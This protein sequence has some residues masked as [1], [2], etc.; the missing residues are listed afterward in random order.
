VLREVAPNVFGERKTMRLETNMRRCELARVCGLM[1][2]ACWLPACGGDAER[3]AQS[4]RIATLE[5]QV[6]QLVDNV[7]AL[8]S[9]TAAQTKSSTPVSS[10]APA[11]RVACPQPWLIHAPLGAALWSCRAP[12]PTPQGLY[13]QCNV[14]FQ[15]QV[16]I[17]T[18][19]YFELALNASPQLFEVKNLKDKPAKINGA[20][21]FEAT[22][23]ADPKPVPLTMMSALMPHA[24]ATYAVTCFAPSAAFDRYTKAFRQIIDTFAFN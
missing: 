11:F 10:P 4:E 14:V 16:A 15:P 22:F 6:R 24:E 7:A 12:E 9:A 5:Q 21:G 13:A 3:T 18:K 19:N 17:E 23:E 2:L 20:D 1:M 8:Q